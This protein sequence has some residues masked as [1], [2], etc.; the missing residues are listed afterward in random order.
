MRP[1][2]VRGHTVSV[3]IELTSKIILYILYRT[4]YSHHLFCA[5][6]QM[7][8][9]QN[10]KYFGMPYLRRQKYVTSQTSGLDL[11]P[12]RVTSRPFSIP[13][14]LWYV[15]SRTQTPPFNVEL[16]AVLQNLF[17]IYKLCV[18][19]NDKIVPFSQRWGDGKWFWEDAGRFLPLTWL[20][21]WEKPAG[22]TTLTVREASGWG[23]CLKM[24]TF[25]EH[26]F[27]C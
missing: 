12:S 7:V 5:N 26:D 13:L 21:E 22:I 23:D 6:G 24:G 27:F 14:Y 8:R 4:L 17:L 19:V 11:E 16:V 1:S 18:I 10:N 2:M 20:W 25:G 9:S 15:R 3:F